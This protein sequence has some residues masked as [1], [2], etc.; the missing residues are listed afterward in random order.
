MGQLNPHERQTAHRVAVPLQQPVPVKPSLIP[1]DVLQTYEEELSREEREAFTRAVA[2]GPVELPEMPLVE[3]L[4][5]VSAEH[6]VGLTASTAADPEVAA[7]ALSQVSLFTNLPA[8]SLEALLAEARQGEVAAGEYLFREGDPAGSFYV[9]VEGM[10]EILRRR[11]ERE[12][13][14]RHLGKGEPIGLFGLFSGALRAAC[15]RAIGD[16]MLLEIPCEALGRL[17]QTDP[18]LHERLLDFYRERLLEGFLGSSR[19]FVDVDSIARARIIGRFVERSLRAQETLVHP[20]EVA[21]LLAVV[22]SGRVL[23]EHKPRAGQ[24]PVLHEATQGQ[25]IAV[26]SALSGAPCRARVYV[27]EESTVAL[28][29]HRELADLLRDYPALRALPARLAEAA[30]TVNRDVFSG[31]TGVPGL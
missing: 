13:A 7:Y 30:K 22:L 15:A 24:E 14:L 6:E 27:P 23:V 25:F 8:R 29:G 4:E 17:V 1:A 28:L 2:E 18:M 11:D 20:G 9:V 12:V 5:L 19:L 10:V 16:V 21:N 26:T 31:S 3:D